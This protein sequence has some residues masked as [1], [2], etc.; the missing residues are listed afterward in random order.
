[1]I[2]PEDEFGETDTTISMPD[3][4]DPVMKAF[5][6]LYAKKYFENSLQFAELC[7]G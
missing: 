3:I 4:N 5:Q 2:K 1:M 7:G 6:L